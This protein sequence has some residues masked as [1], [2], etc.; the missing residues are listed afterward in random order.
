MTAVR[1]Y[2][3]NCNSMKY[4]FSLGETYRA[5]ERPVVDATQSCKSK[6]PQTIHGSLPHERSLTRYHDTPGKD[7]IWE[8]KYNN[9]KAV[10]PSTFSLFPYA[11]RWTRQSPPSA[12]SNSSDRPFLGPKQDMRCAYPCY[13]NVT[14]FLLARV[15]R[16]SIT[17]SNN[18]D[19]AT[20]RTHSD[21][22]PASCRN[23]LLSW[24]AT[25]SDKLINSY[26]SG[27]KSH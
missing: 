19:D 21:F 13:E 3:E 17:T 25:G 1:I 10:K 20:Y 6:P 15:R 26:R 18:E 9:P 12:R 27:R 14:G 7:S 23:S 2:L 24:R 4:Q 22:I 11:R 16:I 8:C 5:S